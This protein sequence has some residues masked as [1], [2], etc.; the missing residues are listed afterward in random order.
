MKSPLIVA[1]SEFCKALGGRTKT[2]VGWTKTEDVE[3]TTEGA[4][5]RDKLVALDDGTGLE[6]DNGTELDELDDG[7]GLELDELDDG[8]ELE[9]DELDDGTELELDELDDGI[10][11]ELDDGT[12]VGLDDRTGV[13][14]DLDMVDEDGVALTEGVMVLIVVDAIEGVIGKDDSCIEGLSVDEIAKTKIE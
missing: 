14:E 1:K 3:E 7:I 8:T 12:G 11:M 2:L 13:W 6:L 5:L 4:L 10:G 9:L